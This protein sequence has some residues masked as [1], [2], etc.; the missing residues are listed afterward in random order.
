M[1]ALRTSLRVVT[2]FF[3]DTIVHRRDLARVLKVLTELAIDESLPPSPR[4]AMTYPQCFLEFLA[5]C[6]A[7]SL[8]HF[9]V[10]RRARRG[11]AARGAWV[12]VHRVLRQ[13]LICRLFFPR[14]SVKY[15]LASLLGVVC[16]FFREDVFRDLLRVRRWPRHV[17]VHQ[18]GVAV[19]RTVAYTVAFMLPLQ[20]WCGEVLAQTTRRSNA[21]KLVFALSLANARA[22][23]PVARRVFGIAG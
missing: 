15:N 10:S 6:G 14:G 4:A 17:D 5:P 21:K 22:V 16:T 3:Y 7:S 2:Y 1:T 20:E 8:I 13:A 18:G 19:L 12:V 11:G 9:L 23:Y